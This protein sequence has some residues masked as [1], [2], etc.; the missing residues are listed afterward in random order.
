MRPPGQW[1]RDGRAVAAGGAPPGGSQTQTTL[2]WGEAAMGSPAMLAGA[3]LP[4][5]A[6][7]TF[8][9]SLVN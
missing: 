7:F 9:V 3:T 5:R 8:D 1:S 4:L 6:G 2:V